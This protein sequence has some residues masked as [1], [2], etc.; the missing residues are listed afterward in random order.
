MINKTHQEIAAVSRHVFLHKVQYGEPQCSEGAQWQQGAQVL[1]EH[2]LG[3]SI[4]V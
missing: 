2:L 4:D 3:G 1:Q